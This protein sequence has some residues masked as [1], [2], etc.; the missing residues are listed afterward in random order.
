MKEGIKDDDDARARAR[1]ANRNKARAR[2]GI[3][4]KIARMVARAEVGRR[5]NRAARTRHFSQRKGKP[6]GQNLVDLRRL[7]PCSRL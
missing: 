5:G 1:R 7:R 3:A 2:A 4:R 6:F